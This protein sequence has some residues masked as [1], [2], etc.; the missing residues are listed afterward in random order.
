M[1]FDMSHEIKLNKILKEELRCH[2]CKSLPTLDGL[3]RH[4]CA[5]YDNHAICKSCYKK[6]QNCPCGRTV[7]MSVCSITRKLFKT[8]K[9]PISCKFNNNGCQILH[10][11][12]QKLFDHEN[13]CSFSLKNR[14]FNLFKS[15][16]DVQNQCEICLE[17][18]DGGLQECIKCILQSHIK[19][20]M[21]NVHRDIG[22]IK[23]ENEGLLDTLQEHKKVHCQLQIEIKN[24]KNL[25][26]MKNHENSELKKEIENMKLANVLLPMPLLSISK[27]VHIAGV[28]FE[29]GSE[30]ETY[31]NAI[32]HL[33]EEFCIGLIPSL[34]LYL[35][36][37]R[38]L[39]RQ[40]FFWEELLSRN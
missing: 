16:P 19:N 8:R 25:V 7:N 31:E 18:F 36:E 32:Y 26:Q 35:K 30:I 9:L 23:I 39:S 28:E 14:T 21:E 6:N 3:E 4:R 2:R 15:E 22:T 1:A 20:D 13:I 34:D 24:E 29:L 17:I 27:K 40:Q 37:V 33:G 12:R 11:D 38:N 5:G 10:F